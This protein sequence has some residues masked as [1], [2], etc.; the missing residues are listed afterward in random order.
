[1]QPLIHA[2]QFPVL[3]AI[4]NGMADPG[5][6]PGH[7]RVVTKKH[8]KIIIRLFSKCHTGGDEASGNV[9]KLENLR[10]LSKTL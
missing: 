7:F 2:T 4:A 6:C 3:C 10:D 1:M 8:V 5:K 9:F